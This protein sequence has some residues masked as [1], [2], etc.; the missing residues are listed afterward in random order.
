VDSTIANII[1]AKG[2]TMGL[3]Y[4]CEKESRESWSGYWCSQC[5][6]IKNLANV[7]GYDRVLSILNECCIRNEDQLEKK[8]LN[9]KNIVINPKIIDE[10]SE[11]HLRRKSDRLNK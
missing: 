10:E 5:R 9:R 4:F 3:C 1:Y 7:Y 8:I 6:K 2:I 11:F